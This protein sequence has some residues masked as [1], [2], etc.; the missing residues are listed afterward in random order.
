MKPSHAG[1][2]CRPRARRSAPS[3]SGSA[4]RTASRSPSPP[5]FDSRSTCP[6]LEAMTTPSSVNRR[7]SGKS[8]PDGLGRLVDLVDQGD[9]SR[10]VGG[11]PRPHLELSAA[12]LVVSH[13]GDQVA[14]EQ[15]GEVVGQIDAQLA[16]GV[17]DHAVEATLGTAGAAVVD[18][19]AQRV[20]E[21]GDQLVAASETEGHD[22]VLG[23]LGEALQ[24]LVGSLQG[25]G[26]RGR[27]AHLQRVV[28]VEAARR[29]TCARRCSSLPG[30]ALRRRAARSRRVR[31]GPS[32][33]PSRPC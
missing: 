8:L 23:Q 22:A 15:H 30:W 28:A 2:G 4:L 32:A 24:R 21:P 16:L 18:R 3:R 12:G 1:C 6:L 25:A 11:H 14:P 10:P 19:R 9:G 7:S 33:S 27:P 26:S 5:S 13:R 17:G 29:T 20:E 31:S